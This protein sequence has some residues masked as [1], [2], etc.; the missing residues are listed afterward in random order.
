M[1]T[2]KKTNIVFVTM[3]A[4]WLVFRVTVGAPLLFLFALLFVY[5]LLI[6]YGSY[7]IGSGFFFDVICSGDTSEKKIALSFDDGPVAEQTS[8][9][10]HLLQHHNISAAFFCIGKRIQGNEAIVN[11]IHQQGHL[12]GNHSYT[13]AFDF[14]F[15]PA[16]KILNDLQQM[17]ETLKP[18]LP[19]KP[20]FFRPPY[21]VTTP[22]MKRA[23]ESGNYIPIGWNIRSMDTVI[24]D[25]E[26]LF[27]K[28]SKALKPGAILLF[29][30]TGK[31]TLA[32]LPRLIEYALGK[33]YQFVRLD[34]LINK[35]AYA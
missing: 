24:H 15:Y 33:G 2:F 32:V 4:L 26:K 28:V 8:A 27:K 9:I 11:S 6:F 35:E 30:D 12:I 10:L 13:H 22:G 14:D 21:G 1:L 29:H 18:I 34:K 17:D 3:L 16:K 20:R 31:V 19:L 23:I 7:Y 5:S 25:E